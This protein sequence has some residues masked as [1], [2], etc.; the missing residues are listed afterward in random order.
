MNLINIYL[1]LLWVI[2]DKNLEF[3]GFEQ[4]GDLYFQIDI[5]F[6]YIINCSALLYYKMVLYVSIQQLVP[7]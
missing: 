4:L 7:I 5:N 6:I 1:M 2:F 3:L